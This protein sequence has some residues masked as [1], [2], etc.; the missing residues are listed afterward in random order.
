M[1]DRESTARAVTRDAAHRE[2]SSLVK[3]ASASTL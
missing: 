3:P 1:Y 2:L